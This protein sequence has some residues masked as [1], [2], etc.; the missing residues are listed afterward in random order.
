MKEKKLH[1]V[2]A[3]MMAT[4]IYSN[5]KTLTIMGGGRERERG[6]GGRERGGERAIDKIRNLLRMKTIKTDYDASL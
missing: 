4:I 1:I 3:F 5:T 6:G 2:D